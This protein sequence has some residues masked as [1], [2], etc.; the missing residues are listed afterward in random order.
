[1]SYRP[2]HVPTLVKHESIKPLP[3]EAL[4]N[5]FLNL[6]SNHIY[7]PDDFSS[8]DTGRA[9]MQYAND[10]LNPLNDKNS[11]N[12]ANNVV[13]ETSGQLGVNLFGEL[14]GWIA[15]ILSLIKLIALICGPI[16]LFIVIRQNASPKLSTLKTMVRSRSPE[17]AP[18]IQVATAPPSYEELEMTV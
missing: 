4:V 9:A 2:P 5:H 10:Q 13:V 1:M 11:D 7:S 14:F 17:S 16:A 3:S 15:N 6:S 18:I 12:H 8:V